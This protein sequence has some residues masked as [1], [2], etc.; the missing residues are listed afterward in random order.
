[1]KKQIA[2]IALSLVLLPSFLTLQGQQEMQKAVL[3]AQIKAQLSLLYL[4]LYI[5]TNQT[6]TTP[7][8]KPFTCPVYH[9]CLMK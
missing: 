4:Q 9:K 6:T 3:V 8:V 2:G 5:M 1:M 7:V